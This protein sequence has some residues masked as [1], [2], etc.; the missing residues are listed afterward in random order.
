MLLDSSGKGNLLANLC[1]CGAGELQSSSVG[2]DGNDLGTGGGRSNVDHE[3]FVL[4]ELGD[5]CLLAIGSLDSEKTA[6]K[7]VVDLDFRV[8]GG[9]LAAETQHETDQTVST[10]Q[11]GVD[12]G[13]DTWKGLAIRQLGRGQGKGGG[14]MSKG[15]LTDQTTGDSKLQVVVLGKE[16]DDSAEDRLALDLALLVLADDTGP[17]LD[18]VAKLQHTGKDGA[19]SNTTLQVLNLGTWL[20]DIEGSDD[21]HVGGGREVSWRDGD[22]ADEVLVDGVDVELQLGRDGDDGAAICDGATDETQ[23]GF[24]VLGGGLFTHQVDLVLQDDDVVQLHDFNGCKM[25]RGLRLRAGFVAC[26]EEEGGVHDGGAGQH[27]AHENVVTGAI[28]ETEQGRRDSQDGR[29]REVNGRW[30]GQLTRRV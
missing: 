1:A 20:V 14:S 27:G 30:R 4:C 15:V 19:T 28:D 26:N 22:L 29:R 23:D 5:L 11:S 12:T 18:L 13:T 8:D 21:N 24:V 7:E 2:L 16:R 25:L 3:D 10:A 9:E 17:D 6:K